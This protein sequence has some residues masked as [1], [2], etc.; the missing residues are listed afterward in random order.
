VGAPCDSS[1]RRSRF[2]AQRLSASQRWARRVTLLGV[3]RPGVLNAFRH[4]RGGR[5]Q[6]LV[7]A[8]ANSPVLNAFRHHRGGRL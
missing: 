5:P 4:H 1:Q 2:G 6:L 7:R 8:A 3:R